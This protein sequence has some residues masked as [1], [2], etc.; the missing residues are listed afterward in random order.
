MEEERS[1]D[2]QLNQVGVLILSQARNELYLRMRFLDV[3]LSS[4]F[5]AREEAIETIGTDGWMLYYNSAFLGGLYREKRV[6][7]N[8]AY[9]HIV[10]HCIFRHM[11]HRNGREEGLY[12]LACDIAAES[13]V[14]SMQ[15][16]C[17]VKPQSALRR[18]TYRRI[19]KM[20]QTKVLT[21]QII[22][23]QLVKAELSQESIAGLILEFGVDDHRYWPTDEEKEKQQQ[24]EE[25]WQ[26]ISEQAET[27]MDTFSKEEAS[28]S[29]HLI[30]QMRVEN[31]ER[32]N[33]QKFLRKFS[34]LREELA[35]DEDSFD[36]GFYN[37]G[38]SLYKNMPL[39]EPQEWK[40]VKKIEEFVIVVDTSMS[41]SGE[42]VK[43]FLEETYTVL[44]EQ[45]SYFKKVNIH[46]IQ[47]DDAVRA[48]Q[49][50][51]SSG[52]LKAYMENLELIGEGGTDFR[53]AFA[54][55]D[56]LIVKQA[57]SS[58]RGLI[59]FT[60]GKGTYP[61]KLPPYD[62]VFVFMKQDYEADG[63]P[64]WAMK[65]ILTEEEIMA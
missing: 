19:V 16:R 60:D 51:T 30:D 13:I 11:V 54:Y 37:Y 15:H 21:A 48:D 12:H 27:D 17:L 36:Y 18:D 35:V 32:I 47:C 31:R 56:E 34:V 26:D 65:V 64:A 33:Y 44:S 20:A 9:L 39:I 43:R 8:R 25:K 49:K 59:Y 61:A 22:Y 57:F 3:A 52:E 24:I 42:L 14:D 4:L 10:L 23:A 38:L 63:V 45:D 55:V 28:E 29:G 50:I 6:L 5:F 7:V 2:E 41:C 53:P 58:L 62:T 40:E 1:I 46:I